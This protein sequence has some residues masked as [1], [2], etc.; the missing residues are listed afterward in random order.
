MGQPNTHRA[1][2]AAA[3]LFLTTS[4]EAAASHH[5]EARSLSSEVAEPWPGLQSQRGDFLDY[6]DGGFPPSG[7]KVAPSLGAA[8]I[9][10]GLRERREELV[11]AGVKSVDHFV[12]SRAKADNPGVFDHVA[13]RTAYDLMRLRAPSHHLFESHRGYWKR[14]LRRHPLL[15]LPDTARHANKF[16]VEVV[17]VL[18]AMHTGSVIGRRGLARRLALRYVNR[19]VPRLARREATNVGGEPGLILSD[20]ASNPLAYHG[21][22]FGYYARAV[23]LL[24]S[25]ASRAARIALRRVA[26]ASWGLMGPDGDVAYIGRSQEMSW[27]LAFTAYGSEVAA[28][29]E[30]NAGRAAR[31]RAVAAHALDRLRHAHGIG[32]FGLWVTPSL[33]ID[34]RA[35]RRGVDVYAN[36]AN[37]TG[38]TLMPLNWLAE[39]RGPAEHGVGRLAADSPG[40]AQ[41]APPDR[42]RFAVVR[43][44]NVWFAV[45]RSRSYSADDLRYDFGLVALKVR[46]DGEWR[47][48]L[49]LRP[50]TKRGRD[51]AGPRL[52]GTL[53][54]GHRMSIARSGTVKVNASFRTSSYRAVRSG[55]HVRF[56]PVSCGVAIVFPTRR[57]DRFRHSVFF[58]QTPEVGPGRVADSSQRVTFS[59]NARVS[60]RRGYSSGLDPKLVRADLAFPRS[61]GGRVRITICAP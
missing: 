25:R 47:D 54:D 49:R 30:R 43:T 50:H 45:K 1:A 24:G 9:Q 14:W 15:W 33:R 55:V 2:L 58:R 42:T 12:V 21:L 56:E 61:D 60:L 28:R 27:A 36:S 10:T 4:G 57:G 29:F 8:L 5:D 37:Y 41:F 16:L 52:G 46:S 6:V 19:V 23:E 26:Q 17:A 39:L 40:S 51:S 59:P 48:V 11:D 44:R 32:P 7:Q 38:L 18:Q 3:A 13:V 35:A 22:S 53:P 20:P 34:P 31:F